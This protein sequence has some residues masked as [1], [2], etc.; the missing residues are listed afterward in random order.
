MPCSAAAP[1]VAVWKSVAVQ[2]GDSDVIRV[3]QQHDEKL[4]PFVNDKAIYYFSQFTSLL[5]Y[6]G[7]VCLFSP[8]HWCTNVDV[9]CALLSKSSPGYRYMIDDCSF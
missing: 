2:C 9:T 3:A 8:L 1:G 7:A 6:K 4:Q 5:M